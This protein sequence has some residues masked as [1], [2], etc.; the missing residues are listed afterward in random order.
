MNVRWFSKAA[1][2]V[3]LPLLAFGITRLPQTPCAE[4]VRK[5]PALRFGQS[6]ALSDFDSDGLIDQ[7]RVDRI[8]AQQRVEIAL[9]HATRRLVLCFEAPLGEQGSLVAEDV[10]SDGATDL[11]WTDLLHPGDVIVWLGD[12]TGEFERVSATAYGDRFTLG[13][14]N[15]GAP[16]Q[17]SRESAISATSRPFD[18][19]FVQISVIHVSTPILSMRGNPAAA[20]SAILSQPSDRSP[21]FLFS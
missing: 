19:S 14:T 4:L 2:F 5:Q 3:L 20:L 8:G 6:V 15:I 17:S 18:Q 11:V 13:S 16:E 9:S 1:L 10:D 21:P 12:G 7:A